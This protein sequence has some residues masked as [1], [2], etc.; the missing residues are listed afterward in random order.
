MDLADPLY[1]FFA[2]IAKAF[3]KAEPWRSLTA[4]THVRLQTLSD[5]DATPLP[6]FRCVDSKV[7]VFRDYG[8]CVQADCST[9]VH[10]YAA[11]EGHVEL[12]VRPEKA[13]HDSDEMVPRP[14]VNVYVPRQASEVSAESL[15]KEKLYTKREATREELLA[16]AIAAAAAI[17]LRRSASELPL[18]DLPEAARERCEQANVIRYDA[19]R[20]PLSLSLEPG[21]PAIDLLATSPC[22]MPAC[23]R[24]CSFC[25]RRRGSTYRCSQ[26]KA[27]YY[28]CPEHQRLHWKGHKK[29]CRAAA[30][31]AA[32]SEI[33]DLP[34]AC[35]QEQLT[36][37][38]AVSRWS[39]SGRKG[40]WKWVDVC[41]EQSL[42]D[43]HGGRGGDSAAVTG[44]D[45]EQML[46]MSAEEMWAPLKPPA[47]TRPAAPCRSWPEL[48]QALGVEDTGR[49]AAA[50]SSVATV[51]HAVAGINA[52][53]LERVANTPS[54]L[55][56]IHLVDA[57]F[58]VLMLPVLGL[59]RALLPAGIRYRIVLLGKRV[60]QSQH[61]S[62]YE[63]GDDMVPRAVGSRGGIGDVWRGCE[64]DFAVR[65][66][67]DDYTSFVAKTAHPENTAHVVLCLLA[68]EQRY[69]FWTANTHS[70][71]AKV[72][73]AA[74]ESVLVAAYSRVAADSIARVVDA[75][76]VGQGSRKAVPATLNPFRSPVSEPSTQPAPAR[77]NAYIFGWRPSPD[78]GAVDFPDR[79]PPPPP[80][81]AP[82]TSSEDK[83]SAWLGAGGAGNLTQPPPPPT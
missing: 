59:L 37:R 3:Q 80:P 69:T 23:A 47:P 38:A 67:C 30:A 54:K 24:Q 5:E 15:E 26:C 41:G 18:E 2:E 72:C 4:N 34:L 22:A 78:L 12:E 28:C 46:S 74:G 53:V 7:Q 66:Y 68:S 1:A 36:S 82:Q 76:G 40:V 58:E 29:P 32:D 42:E 27:A 13:S 35:A 11:P 77:A 61:Y 57:G 10:L 75:A 62:V 21:A 39:E 79:A 60:P 17:S 55:C 6:Y 71:S 45:V 9:D 73:G 49:H 56:H 16:L 20:F 25:G 70:L 31:M 51:Y 52:A 8:D 63:Y 14:R 50:L 48:L 83:V 44:A 64:G 33:G 81:S 19:F 65:L 43:V